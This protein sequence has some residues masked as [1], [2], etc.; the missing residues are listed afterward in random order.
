MGPDAC[1]GVELIL[2]LPSAKISQPEDGKGE[3]LCFLPLGGC[4]GG[5][6]SE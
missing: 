3:G 6:I 1:D 2:S 4:L 5:E